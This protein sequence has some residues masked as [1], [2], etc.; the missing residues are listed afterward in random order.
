MWTEADLIS[1]RKLAELC[2]I[3]QETFTS[4]RQQ[5]LGNAFI[6]SPQLVILY[7]FLMNVNLPVP[8]QGMVV[9]RW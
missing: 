3:K 8:D 7:V 9:C 4:Q 1:T 2:H 5:L 6:C